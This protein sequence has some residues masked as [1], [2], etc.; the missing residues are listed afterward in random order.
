MTDQAIEDDGFTSRGLVEAK[1]SLSDGG[2]L[3]FKQDDIEIGVWLS[4]WTG[5]EKIWLNGDLV[6]ELRT[7]GFSPWHRFEHDDHVYE[8]VMTVETGGA[9]MATILRDGE[10]LFRGMTRPLSGTKPTSPLKVGVW[11]LLSAAFGGV[12]GYLGI[13]TVIAWFGG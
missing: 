4:A 2:Q 5:K 12:L 7:V 8:A 3:K 10:V 6:S 9:Y 1:L 11:A 13:S